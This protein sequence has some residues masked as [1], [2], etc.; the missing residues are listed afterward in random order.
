VG[1]DAKGIFAEAA[2]AARDILSGTTIQDVV[3]RE[4]RDAGVAMYYI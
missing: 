3:D 4:V 1:R 2:G